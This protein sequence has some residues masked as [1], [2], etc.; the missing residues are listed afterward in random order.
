MKNN[1]YLYINKNYYL[2]KLFRTKKL[3]IYIYINLII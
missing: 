1:L 2:I 3:I